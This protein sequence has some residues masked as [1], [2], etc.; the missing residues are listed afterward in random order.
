MLKHA[1]YL[2]GEP[3]YVFGDD[4]KDYFNHVVNAAEELWKM[5]TTIRLERSSRPRPGTPNVQRRP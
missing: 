1:A 4:A 2:M 5:N 3:I